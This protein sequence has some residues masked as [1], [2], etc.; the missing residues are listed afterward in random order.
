MTPMK[1]SSDKKVCFDPQWNSYTMLGGKKLT[2]VSAL[3]RKFKNQFDS[4]YFSKKAAEK[5]GVSQQ[6]ILDEWKAKANKSIAIGNAVHKIFE[7][8]VNKN[9]SLQNGEL[10]FDI[11]ISPEYFL[12]FIPVK[13]A[14][15]RFIKDF[16]E[17]GRLRPI[18]TEFIVNDDNIATM[19]DTYCE[20]KDSR[21][22]VFDFKTGAVESNAYGKKM[23]SI[24]NAIDDCSL[25]H[26]KLQLNIISRLMKEAVKG[27]YIVQ[28]SDTYKLIP[29][30]DILGNISLEELFKN[31][32]L[33]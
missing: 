5:R 25:N 28:I 17:S 11:N 26:Y 3:L 30:D 2:S 24:L 19:L 33:L 27:C 6:V 16:F 7:D 10:C 8:Y 12:D 23:L 18:A 32:K 1:C 21:I 31:Y 14:T 20:D 22:W 15:F 29:V 9:Y 4:D 13:N